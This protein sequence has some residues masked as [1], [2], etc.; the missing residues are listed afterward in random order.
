MAAIILFNNATFKSRKIETFSNGIDGPQKVN[1]SLTGYYMR[2]HIDL[3]LNLASN[4]TSQHNWIHFRL[5]EMLLNYAEALN[6]A[7]GAVSDVYTAVNR[8]RTRVGMPGLPAGLTME[9]MRARIR[10]ERRIELSF[11]GHRYWDARRWD[12]AKTD[13]NRKMRGVKIDQPSPG[14]FVYTPYDLEERVFTA[15]MNRYPI[16]LRDILANPK[17]EQ[18]DGWK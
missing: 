17:L 11:E 6:E 16:Q 10:N 3:N 7:D 15:N 13:F 2:K 9:Q 8:I 5:A 1:G 18:N 4:Q 12:I 14:V